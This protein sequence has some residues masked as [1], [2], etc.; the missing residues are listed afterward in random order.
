MKL[1]LQSR[2]ANS[3]NVF[4]I[5]RKMAHCVMFSSTKSHRELGICYF[6]AEKKNIFM[7]KKQSFILKMGHDYGRKDT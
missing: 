5:M 2:V 3:A 4:F 7:G 1:T 6:K